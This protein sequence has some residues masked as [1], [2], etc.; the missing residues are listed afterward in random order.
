MLAQQ[1]LLRGPQ[2][3]KAIPPNRDKVPSVRVRMPPRRE[4]FAKESFPRPERAAQVKSSPSGASTWPRSPAAG[5]A[6]PPATERPPRRRGADGR[7]SGRKG[8]AGTPGT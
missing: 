4:G 6:G 2:E 8:L 1:G 3:F 7:G 5:H